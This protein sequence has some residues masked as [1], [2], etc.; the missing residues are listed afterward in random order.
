MSEILII[1]EGATEREIGK[2]LYERAVLSQQASPKPP[3]WKGQQREGTEQVLKHTRDIIEGSLLQSSQQERLLLV[4]DQEDA[5][6][7]QAR[8]EWIGQRLNLTFTPHRSPQFSNLF[9]SEKASLRVLLH[10][11]NAVV[12][13]S[14]RG[15]FDGYILQLLQGAG[16]I[17]IAQK[18]IGNNAPL[19]AQQLLDKA[20]KE[21]TDLMQQNG[22]PWTHAKSWLYGYITA[23]QYRNSHVA[24]ARKVVECAE[25]AE[26]CSTFEALITA[27][28][29]LI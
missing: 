20:E 15:D 25:E 10:I 17:Q 9:I 12:P 16:K 21:M 29:D 2:V 24:F 14:S 13:G 23:F 5:P 3:N 1:T 6:T 28:N 7:P 22:Y 4:F 26:L 8:A 18:I 27:W 11:S 19:S